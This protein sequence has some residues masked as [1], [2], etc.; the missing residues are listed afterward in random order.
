MIFILGGNGFVG[1]AF[2]RFCQSNGLDYTIID[3]TNYDE[4]LGKSCDVFINANGNSSKILAKKDPLADFDATVRSTKKSL[5]DFQFE[6]YVLLSSCDVYPD[7]SS[8]ETTR[9]DSVIDISKQ[10]PY[11]FHKLLAEE[12]VRHCASNWLIIRMGGMVGIGLKKNPIFDIING[13]LLWVDPKSE[14]QYMN[15]EDVAK[16]VFELIDKEITNQIFNVC[17]SSLMR[18]DELLKTFHVR[19]NQNSPLVRYDVNI[20]KIQKIVKMPD[21]IESVLHFVKKVK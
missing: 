15:T 17:G 12:C 11:G 8:P 10:S 4:H 21:S 5:I 20:D 18:I 16:T 3:R 7:C 2:V 6:K 13:G 19:V 14:L 9:E 1:S